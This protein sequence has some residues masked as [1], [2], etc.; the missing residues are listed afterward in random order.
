ML[1]LAI[2]KHWL[3]TTQTIGYFAGYL[4]QGF[5]PLSKTIGKED[6]LIIQ[7]KECNYPLP[8]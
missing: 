2:Q 4:A 5:S 8:N 7:N 3:K 6:V 1:E